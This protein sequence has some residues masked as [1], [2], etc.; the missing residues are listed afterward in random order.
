[1][2]S[3]KTEAISSLDLESNQPLLPDEDYDDHDNK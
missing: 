3:R 2:T 1:M